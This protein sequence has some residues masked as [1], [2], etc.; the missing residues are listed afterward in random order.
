M[1]E[2]CCCGEKNSAGQEPVKD[3]GCGRLLLSIC[4]GAAH[5]LPF[6]VNSL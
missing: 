2:T 6:R 3:C 1:A 4:E 5:K